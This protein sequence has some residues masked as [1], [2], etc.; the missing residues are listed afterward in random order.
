MDLSQ[1]EWTL[2]SAESDSAVIIDVRGVD[3]W[4]DGIIPGAQMHD[5]HDAH[6]FM[7]MLGG[8]D[9]S[10]SYFVVCRT[11]DRGSQA[12]MIMRSQGFQHVFN[13]VGGMDEW[14]GEIEIPDLD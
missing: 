6:A 9:K 5:I 11:G 3:E 10:G 2:R 8:L 14:E 4:E 1:S 12:E 13:L 7:S